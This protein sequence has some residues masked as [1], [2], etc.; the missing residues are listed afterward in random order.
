MSGGPPQE[1]GDSDRIAVIGHPVECDQERILKQVFG[2]IDRG[3][4]SA[5]V[6]PQPELMASN[7][8]LEVEGGG[9]VGGE[10]GSRGHDNGSRGCRQGIQFFAIARADL[11]VA[12]T[13]WPSI[14]CYPG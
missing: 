8:R 5:Q 12:H 13:A 4:E 14:R 6:T 2:Q 9:H 7:Q 10:Y 1:R 11:P 3:A